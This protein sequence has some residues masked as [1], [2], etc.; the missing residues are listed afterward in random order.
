M[1]LAFSDVITFSRF[2]RSKAL[3]AS[4]NRQNTV[5]LVDYNDARSSSCSVS[6]PRCSYVEAT[7]MLWASSETLD[8]LKPVVEAARDMLCKEG[9]QD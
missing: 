2:T 6:L 1:I 8:F 5:C 9:Q 7:H 3:A 4:P